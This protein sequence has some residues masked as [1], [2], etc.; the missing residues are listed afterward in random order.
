MNTGKLL[1]SKIYQILDFVMRLVIL[2]VIIVFVSLPLFTLL[3]AI[4]AGHSVIRKMAEDRGTSIFKEFFRTFIQVLGKTA[5][6]S[7][8]II[9]VI[10]VLIN[11]G[12]FFFQTMGDGIIYVIGFL[13]T[14]S[15]GFVI[16]ACIQHLPIIISYFPDL[17]TIDSIK[18]MFLFS[19]RYPMLTIYLLLP[20]VIIFVEIGLFY[21]IVAFLGFSL[22]IYV[23]YLLSYRSYRVI[24]EKNKGD[25]NQ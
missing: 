12:F 8:F 10:V 19:A 20:V 18:L 11:S 7:L 15:V 13:L 3:A 1:N 6:L 14:I 4:T 5:M 24:Y 22:P 17:R 16:I 25:K 2:N 23:G 9:L 21:G